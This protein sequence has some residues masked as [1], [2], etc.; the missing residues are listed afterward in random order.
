L[1]LSQTFDLV[2]RRGRHDLYGA[3]IEV[4]RRFAEAFLPE[5]PLPNP[6]DLPP[7]AGDVDLRFL[8]GVYVPTQDAGA[9]LL[10]RFGRAAGAFAVDVSDR[11]VRVG[12]EGPFVHTGGGVLAAPSGEARW[13]VTRTEHDTFLQRPSDP[14][15]RMYVKKPWHWNATVTVLPLTLP[16]LLAIPACLFGFVNRRSTPRRRLGY[17]LALAG[18]AVA[19]GLYFELEHFSENYYPDGPTAALV[20]WRLLLNFAWLAALAALWTIA[21]H[22]RPSLRGIAGISSAAR[23]F[24]VALLAVSALTLVVLLPYWGLVGNLVGA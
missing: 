2:A 9:Q 23:S 11:S 7:V 12:D 24:F 8:D 4:E 20:A 22:P 19:V 16:I 1:N 3:S 17:L 13:L 15:F 6:A 21:A 10:L 18:A 5:A 14:A